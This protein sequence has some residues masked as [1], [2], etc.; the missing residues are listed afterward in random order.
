LVESF[1]EIYRHNSIEYG[2][3]LYGNMIDLTEMMLQVYHI[4]IEKK[5]DLIYEAGTII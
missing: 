3:S 2:G 1:I 4:K 5:S